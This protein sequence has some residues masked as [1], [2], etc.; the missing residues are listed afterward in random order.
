MTYGMPSIRQRGKI[1]LC[2]SKYTVNCFNGVY[3][4]KLTDEIEFTE[5]V[6]TTC[7]RNRWI[8][9]TIGSGFFLKKICLQKSM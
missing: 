2:I 8:L 4:V 1:F 5:F 9:D 6:E 7:I 3:K